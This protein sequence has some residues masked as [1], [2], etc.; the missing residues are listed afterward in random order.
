MVKVCVVFLFF[1]LSGCCPY[2]VASD[3]LFFVGV[4]LNCLCS[5]LLCC[6]PSDAS[7]VSL[8]MLLCP[9]LVR[10]LPLP[11]LCIMLFIPSAIRLPVLLLLFPTYMCKYLLFLF[12]FIIILL[13]LLLLLLVVLII[14]RSKACQALQ[15][16]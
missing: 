8:L 4:G 7:L 14:W 15:T 2:N 1:F 16:F 12:L 10:L 6:C 11:I 5:A 3:I 13:R 9:L